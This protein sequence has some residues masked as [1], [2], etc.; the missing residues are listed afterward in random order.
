MKTHADFMQY[1]VPDGQVFNN[2]KNLLEF[3][4]PKSHQDW[5]EFRKLGFGAS[6]Q[7]TVQG[8]NDWEILPT[9]LEKK[10]GVRLE[11]KAMNERMLSGIMAESIILERWRYYDGTDSGYIE[12][13]MA[14]KK[15]REVLPVS[16][17]IVNTKYPRLFVS[18]DGKAIPNQTH[19]SGVK[20]PKSFPVECKTISM[21]EAKKWHEGIPATYRYQVQQQM[22]V[23]EVDYAELATLEDGYKFT[24]HPFKKDE[25]MQ[26]QIITKTN[27]AWALGLKLIEMKQE[28]DH[29]YNHD[30][31][32]KAEQVKSAYESI[33]P[34]PGDQEAFKDYYSE[35]MFNERNSFIGDIT[36]FKLAN[37]RMKT[38]EA[39]KQL[40]SEKQQY[41]NLLMRSF[42]INQAE[43]MDFGKQ[44][45][46]RYYKKEG[47]KNY[48]FSFTGVKA[49]IDK[50]AISRIIKNITE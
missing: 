49:N 23:T 40:E 9:L 12:N 27:D 24:V 45:K 17:Y 20:V 47:G 25:M 3:Q 50:E 10:I 33:M 14:N 19:L 41:E 38:S 43:Y 32:A 15:I 5:L 11:Q 8:C 16:S 31:H 26:E 30:E 42:V 28:M 48:Q 46:L 29:Y 4:I 13:F 39:I 37:L 2:N 44:G 1:H 18:L 21:M 36:N 34:L 7:G 22:L 35:K 6:E